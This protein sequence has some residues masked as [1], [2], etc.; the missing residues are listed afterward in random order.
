MGLWNK[1][2][3]E[4][5]Q[6]KSEADLLIEKLGPVIGA[7]IEEKLKPVSEKVETLFGKWNKLEED[8]TRTDPPDQRADQRHQGP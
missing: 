1:K 7:A 6:T 3:E 8:A 2:T 4:P 5:T